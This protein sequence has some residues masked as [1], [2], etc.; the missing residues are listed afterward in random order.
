MNTISLDIK[1]LIESASDFVFKQ[2]LFVGREPTSP[3]NVLVIFDQPN[4]GPQLL[5]QKEESRYEYSSIQCRSRHTDYDTA[6][7]WARI[8]VSVLHG[9]GNFELNGAFYTLVRA[10]DNPALLTWDDSNRAKVIVNFEVQR[11]PQPET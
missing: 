5:Y 11:T 8:C 10:L 4:Q 2:D 3:G 1:D 9:I 7:Q 6:M